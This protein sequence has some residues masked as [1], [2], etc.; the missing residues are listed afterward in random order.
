LSGYSRRCRS[1][2]D[3]GCRTGGDLRPLAA[4]ANASDLAIDDRVFLVETPLRIRRRGGNVASMWLAV[5]YRCRPGFVHEFALSFRWRDER[6]CCH[7]SGCFATNNDGF[8]SPGGRGCNSPIRVGM[9]MSIGVGLLI[10]GLR[11]YGNRERRCE[12]CGHA[13]KCKFGHRVAPSD[14]PLRMSASGRQTLTGLPIFPCDR[15]LRF[16]Q[17]IAKDRGISTP[18]C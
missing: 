10:N 13:E 14:F 17:A 8:S 1:W 5:P 3:P 15:R 18:G 2:K 6:R 7:G 4:S 9:V 11:G 12:N 16:L